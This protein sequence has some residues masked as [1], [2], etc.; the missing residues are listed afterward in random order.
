MVALL[1][2]LAEVSGEVVRP[3][4]GESRVVV[5]EQMRGPQ[6]SGRVNRGPMASHVDLMAPVCARA[7]C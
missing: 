3:E 4:V 1:P 5:G 7:D 2:V 6:P